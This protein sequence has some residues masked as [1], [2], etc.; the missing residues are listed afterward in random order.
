MLNGFLQP[1]RCFYTQQNKYSA[2]PE[3]RDPSQQ[4]AFDDMPEKESSD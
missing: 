1:Q 4:S 2:F 3:M